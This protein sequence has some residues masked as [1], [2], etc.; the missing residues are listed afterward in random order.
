[1][2]S[3]KSFPFN[4]PVSFDRIELFSGFIPLLVYTT[5]LIS[6]RVSWI[7]S[8]RIN[9][10]LSSEDISCMCEGARMGPGIQFSFSTKREAIISLPNI[11]QS[12][13]GQVKKLRNGRKSR[14]I[15]QMITR[16]ENRHHTNNMGLIMRF[17]N[18]TSPSL[19]LTSME[20]SSKTFSQTNS[21]LFIQLG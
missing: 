3:V 8:G 4:G 19:H 18:S 9:I 5:Y 20:A 21:S 13:R 10:G 11:Q 7:Q 1:M 15:L 17:P 14:K 6:S 16:D 2:K 12:V